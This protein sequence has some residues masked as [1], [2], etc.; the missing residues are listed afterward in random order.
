MTEYAR[1]S[2]SISGNQVI[3][4]SATG[5]VSVLDEATEKITQINS[6][7]NVDVSVSANG[8]ISIMD[9]ATG[10]IDTFRIRCCISIG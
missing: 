6:A 5:D 2:G 1:A 4:I 9:V 3:Q 7:N 8:D 10:Q